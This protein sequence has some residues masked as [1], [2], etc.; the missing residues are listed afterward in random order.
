MVPIPQYPL[1]SATIA[2]FDM[3]QI[4]YYLD[5]GKN[6]GLDIDELQRAIDEAKKNCAPRAIVII[7]P[8]N[9]TGQ[10]LS[11]DNIEEVI[12]FAH[13]NKLL[14]FADEVYQDNIY[15]TGSKFFSFKKVLH[16]MKEPYHSM[17]LASFM[18]CSKGK[19]STRKYSEN[20]N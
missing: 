9:P 15:A 10:V 8:G 14:I 2:E 19:V 20:V 5:E 7:N 13:R 3:E 18:S 4:G 11:K 16:E 6:W 12:K 1:Y 17:E